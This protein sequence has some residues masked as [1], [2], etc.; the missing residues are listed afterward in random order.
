M[1]DVNNKRASMRLISQLNRLKYS[2]VTIELNNSQID[3]VLWFEIESNRNEN[4]EEEQKKQNYK[5]EYKKR[6]KPKCE[7][8]EGE[9][10]EATKVK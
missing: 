1:D 6:Q 3:P 5:T 4:T 7:W 2:I 10:E 9:E 8:K